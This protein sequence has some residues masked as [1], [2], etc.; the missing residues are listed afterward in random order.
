MADQLLNPQTTKKSVAELF[1]QYFL[2]LTGIIYA[3]GFLVI[4]SFLDRFGILES[5]A[6]FLRTRYLHIGMLCIAL[7]LIV[8]GTIISLVYLI[9]HGRLNQPQMCATPPSDGHPLH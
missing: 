8:N 7:P 4:L 6:D 3:A 5:G 2:A 1:P 9:R